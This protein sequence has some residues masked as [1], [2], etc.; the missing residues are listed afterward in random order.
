MLATHTL[1]IPTYNRPELLARIVLHYVARGRPMELLVLDS[2]KPDIAAANAEALKPHAQHLRHLVFPTTMPMALKLSQGL[3]EV[4]TPTCSFCADDDLVF[5]DGLR[6][7]LVFLRS[8]PGHVSAH[9]LYLN[10]REQKHVVHLTREYAGE[11]NDAATAGGRIFRL[12]Q[13]YES[14]FYGVFRTDDLREIFA[15]VASLPS[16]HYQE[17]FQSVAALIKGKV[18][19]FPKFFAARR[20]GPAAEPERDKWQTY[21]WFAENPSEFMAHYAEYREHLWMFC[22]A[23]AAETSP[24]REAFLKI[25]DLTHAM[26]FSK[27]CPPEY[28]HSILKPS[29]GNDRF[30]KNQADLFQTIRRSPG[31]QK[32]GAAEALTL[33]VLRSLRRRRR[34]PAGGAAEAIAQL[35]ARMRQ[36][37]NSPWTCQLPAGLSWLASNQDF[38]ASYLELCLYLDADIATSDEALHQ[39]ELVG[40][41][42]LQ[43]PD[44]G[45]QL[46]GPQDRI[47]VSAGYEFTRSGGVKVSLRSRDRALATYDETWTGAWR[48]PHPTRV[49]ASFG[50]HDE[51]FEFAPTRLSRTSTTVARRAWEKEFVLLKQQ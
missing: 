26:Y 32:V 35:D 44:H 51:V 14:L 19:R 16:L 48:M 40:Y 38:Q 36:L 12:C 6:D 4:S 46:A 25:V 28:L 39:A 2:S 22:Q 24:D 8:N 27:G 31:Q 13:N 34:P 7:A 47:S 20:S 5:L 45:D 49:E 21:Y 17:L 42:T 41:W 50:T 30:A 1:V 29:L 43:N 15:G 3:A 11:S 9:G 33:R 18:E 23:S 37:G 10:F